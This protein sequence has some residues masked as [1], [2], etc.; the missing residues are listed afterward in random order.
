MS[1]KFIKIVFYLLLGYGV[2]GFIAVPLI[3][4]PQIIQAVANETKADIEI[5][6]IYFN[7]FLFR[8]TLNKVALNSAQKERLVS[9]ERLFVDVELHSLLNAAI[10]IKNIT[11]EKPTLSLTLNRDK[12]V[13][14]L[15]IVNANSQEEVVETQSEKSA[16]PRIIIDKISLKE[17]ALFYQ[18]FTL[19]KPFEFAF[20][21]IGFELKD[22]DTADSNNSQGELRFYTTLGDGGFVDFKSRSLGFAPLKVE[23]SLDFQASKLYTQWRYLQDMLNLEVADGK[24]SLHAEYEFNLDDINATKI[25]NFAMAVEKLRI[26]PKAAPQDVLNLDALYINDGTILPMRQSVNIGKITLDGLGVKVERSSEGVIDWLEYTKITKDTE[27]LEQNSTQ[28]LKGESSTPWKLLIEDIALERI[29]VALRD[30]AIAPSVTT[31]LNELNLYV[32]DVTLA[33]EKP[34]SYSANLRLNEETKCHSEGEIIYA[35]LN[36]ESHIECSGFDITHYTPYIDSEAKK[37]LS[38]Y[39]VG[40]KSAIA[41]FDIYSLLEDINGSMA[42]RLRDSNIS[43]ES[44]ALTEQ[45][46]KKELVGFDKFALN[47]IALDTAKERLNIGEASLDGLYANLK[48]YKDSSL[49]LEH[50]IEVKSDKR[51]KPKLQATQEEQKKS[52]YSLNLEHFALNKATLLFEDNS[53]SQRSVNRVESIDINLYNIDSKEESWL[54][55]DLAL[56]LNR[57]AKLEAKGELS[58]TPLKQRGSFKISDISLKALT[59]YLQERA[60]VSIDDGKLSL[61][62]KTS[63]AKSKRYPDL[64]LEGG[65]NLSSLFVNNTKDDSLLLS[66]NEV[67]IPTY[68]LELF[69]NRLYVD[70]VDVNAFFV[71]AMIDEKRVINFAKL[72]KEQGSDAKSKEIQKSEPKPLSEPSFPVRIMRVNYTLGSA[73]FADYSIPI[74]FKTH[75]HDLNGVLYYLS[76]T[77]GES[78]YIDIVG[79]VDEYG[80]MQLKGSVDSANPRAYTDLDLSFKN[81]ELNALSGYSANF[82]GHKIDSGKLYVD[83]GY[84]ILE[85]E[86][87]GS[88]AVI[89]K[90]MELGEEIE[91]E[92]I[93]KLPLGFVIGL[94]EDSDGIIDVD[95]P[96]TGDLEEPNFEYGTLVWKTF[97]NLITKAVTSPFKF[98]GSLMGID[99]DDLEYISFKSAS[100]EISPPEREKL[101]KVVKI[102][103]KKPKISL[104]I[105]AAYDPIVD[106]RGLQEQK[107]IAIVVEKSGIKNIKEHASVMSIEMLEEI[108]EEKRE[109]GKIEA[110]KKELEQEYE[111]E[112]YERIYQSRLLSLCRAIQVISQEEL[113]ALGD[114]RAKRIYGYLVEQKQIESHRVSMRESLSVEAEN[115]NSINLEMQIEVK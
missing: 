89:I 10:H 17:G 83:L 55:Y 26:K 46:S 73:K 39:N 33:G 30:K 51:S 21:T 62:G 19:K 107:L 54:L 61:E 20:T 115:E 103:R 53:L 78:S 41:G 66:L 82:A 104:K 72:L 43:L 36:L 75:I 110:L 58:H 91:D 100:S 95:M 81:L 1:T 18:D 34:L 64:R 25:D 40:L 7:P 32:R 111:G 4:K 101:D 102:M 24:I 87:I 112:E 50:L 76:N 11:L 15:Q 68:T 60:F 74:K 23:G 105:D 106:K 31:E 98:L 38:T 27:Q 97:T 45:G 94:L 71:N 49:N 57:S 88:N 13:N 12:T 29:A 84:D 14:L 5:D 59:P 108:Y 90:K 69:P 99:A 93:T 37:R 113:I 56:R 16:L 48:K 9:F 52:A 92:N 114:A 85:S 2:L 3:L 65:V 35:L 42:F 6:S 8:L 109:D 77:P 22:I 96:V 63:Y 67:N 47:G 80:S 28:E 79:E 44:V 86:L 70:E